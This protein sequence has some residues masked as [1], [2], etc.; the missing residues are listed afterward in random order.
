MNY[1]E[2]KDVDTKLLKAMIAGLSIC[3]EEDDGRFEV[4]EECKL[5]KAFMVI[6]SEIERREIYSLLNLRG[7][8]QL[9]LPIQLDWVRH[10]SRYADTVTKKL[11]DKLIYSL[12][13]LVEYTQPR[14]RIKINKNWR[15]EGF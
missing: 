7:L 13:C 11:Y 5:Y 2:I 3:I 10:Q 6:E 15:T 14:V 1:Y 8:N 4:F 9:S 12:N